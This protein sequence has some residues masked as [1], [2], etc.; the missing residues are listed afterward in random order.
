MRERAEVRRQ[1]VDQE[2]DDHST[3]LGAAGEALGHDRHLK[4]K[5]LQKAHAFDDP[6]CEV[7][8]HGSLAKQRPICRDPGRT[9]R[10]ASSSISWACA[11]ALING[12]RHRIGSM[13]GRISMGAR[14]EVLSVVAER[15]L[16]A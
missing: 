6:C 11:S 12:W 10:R 16:A 13:A 1:Q 5:H 3:L 4:S 15:Y 14:R 8:E 7:V 9:W 2:Q